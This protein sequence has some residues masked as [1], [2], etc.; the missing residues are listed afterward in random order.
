MQGSTDEDGFVNP[1]DFI[2]SVA[3]MKCLPLLHKAILMQTER[4][5]R[6]EEAIN[7]LKDQIKQFKANNIGDQDERTDSDH[8]N[9]NGGG[10]DG[11]T[12]DSNRVEPIQPSKRPVRVRKV[13]KIKF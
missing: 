2:Y 13:K 10:D 1:E 6:Q 11:S 5:Q 8:V 4:L 12:S 3:Y 9:P 7:E